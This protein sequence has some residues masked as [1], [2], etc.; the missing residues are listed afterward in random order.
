MVPLATVF[1][2]RASFFSTGTLF[3]RKAR[4]VPVQSILFST[5]SRRRPYH[6]TLMRLNPMIIPNVANSTVSVC[7]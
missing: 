5:D 1:L 3:R 6:C 4:I 7:V 2:L